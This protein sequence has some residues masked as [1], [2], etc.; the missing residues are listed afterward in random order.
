MIH[1]YVVADR[2]H[3]AAA[4]DVTGAFLERGSR[5]EELVGVH[6]G[7][8]E[9]WLL[10]LQGLLLRDNPRQCLRGRGEPWLLLRRRRLVRDDRAGVLRLVLRL[11]LMVLLRRL[12]RDCRRVLQ[13]QLVQLVQLMLLVLLRRRRW[14][15]L[16]LD[17]PP[18]R[19]CRAEPDLLLPREA[20]RRDRRTVVDDAAERLAEPRARSHSSRAC[21]RAGAGASGGRHHHVAHHQRPQQSGPAFGDG[22][23][24]TAQRG[25]DGARRQPRPLL[26]G[27][28]RLAGTT[29]RALG[30]GAPPALRDNPPPA[31]LVVDVDHVGA[32]VAG[33]ELPLV[34]ARHAVVGAL[35][36]LLPGAPPPPDGHHAALGVG[37]AELPLLAEDAVRGGREA[38][39]EGAQLLVELDHALLRMLDAAP[40]WRGSG[41]IEDHVLSILQA[42]TGWCGA[43]N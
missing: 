1:A 2:R 10:L 19:V 40:G 24:A 27:A 31:G 32:G 25:R 12:M 43:S 14:P 4:N 34:G 30:R 13:L 17:R 7:T 8:G 36:A 20:V 3:A 28:P 38:A 39:L 42:S 37:G 11:V 15:R 16:G 5:D 21:T 41:F 9:P 29:P 26:G 18:H 35:G 6:R 33:A 23:V 22:A